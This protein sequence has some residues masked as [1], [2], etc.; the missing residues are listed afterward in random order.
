MG[1]GEEFI[2]IT[3]HTDKESLETFVKK[4]QDTI[5]QTNFLPVPKVTASFGIT[6]FEQE[7][8][9]ESIQKRVDDALYMAKNKGR[10]RYE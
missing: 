5:Q 10:D 7:D 3:P 2:I 9:V 6:L 1:G 8:T 4:I